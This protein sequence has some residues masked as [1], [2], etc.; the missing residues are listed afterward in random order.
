MNHNIN[1][2]MKQKPFWKSAKKTKVQDCVLI[3]FIKENN[4]NPMNHCG[5][6]WD[7]FHQEF[8]R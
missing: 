8:H 3:Y 7:H 6:D 5:C 4:Y 2:D 1:F